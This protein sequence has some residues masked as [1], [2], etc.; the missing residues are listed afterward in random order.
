MRRHKEELYDSACDLPSC[1]EWLMACTSFQCG[2]RQSGLQSI[3]LRLLVP[4]QND[5]H[6]R[7][8]HHH[9]Y[10]VLRH[11]QRGLDFHRDVVGFL[12]T[13]SRRLLT[14]HESR[15]ADIRHD[16]SDSKL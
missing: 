14:P 10:H 11:H 9:C 13:P 8:H 1:V 4:P 2:Q 15:G 16:H 7:S 5:R 6:H 12:S 3:L